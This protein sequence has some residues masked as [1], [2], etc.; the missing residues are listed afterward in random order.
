M[1]FPGVVPQEQLRPVHE[2]DALLTAP[3]SPF[4]VHHRQI[5]GLSSPPS[6]STRSPTSAPAGSTRSSRHSARAPTSPPRAKR[7]PTLPYTCVSWHSPPFSLA[8]FPCSRA[9]GWPL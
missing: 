7:T 9:T 3:G 1:D 4:E 2:V 6:G 5:R 8:A